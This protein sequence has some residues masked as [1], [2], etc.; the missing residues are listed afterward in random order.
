MLEMHVQPG[1][2]LR[3]FVTHFM[4]Y[5]RRK[6]FAF[7]MDLYLNTRFC[8]NALYN[9]LPDNVR[10]ALVR[11]R[12]E[13]TVEELAQAAIAMDDEIQGVRKRKDKKGQKSGSSSSSGTESEEEGKRNSPNRNGNSVCAAQASKKGAKRSNRRGRRPSVRAVGIATVGKA[14]ESKASHP[15]RETYDAMDGPLRVEIKDQIRHVRLGGRLYTANQFRTLCYAGRRCF[16]CGGKHQIADC[17][18]LDKPLFPHATRYTGPTPESTKSDRLPLKPW[19]KVDKA[20][21]GKGEA[22]VSALESEWEDGR[23]VYTRESDDEF[24]MFPDESDWE[25]RP[26]VNTLAI[27]RGTITPRIARRR[28]LLLQP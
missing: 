9:G 19:P 11:F 16:S 13:G 14:V 3:D 1:Q 5:M 28:A 8:V 23:Y 22:D 10:V 7:Q 12:S 18:H 17:P 4:S 15:E 21:N 24:C 26:R 20:K 27:W 2:S 25:S 6:T